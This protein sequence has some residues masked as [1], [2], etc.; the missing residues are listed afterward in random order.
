MEDKN[1]K[2]EEQKLNEINDNTKVDYEKPTLDAIDTQFEIHGVVSNCS[3]GHD[4]TSCSTE[5]DN[6]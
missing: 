4:S 2:N 6:N 5:E 1:Y 3:M